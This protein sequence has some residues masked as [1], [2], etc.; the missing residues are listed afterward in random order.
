MIRHKVATV[1]VAVLALWPVAA[2]GQTVLGLDEVLQS[3]RRFAPQVLE[4]VA[5]VRRAEGRQLSAEGAF[6]T[7]VSAEASARITGFWDGRTL[8]GTI[9][10]P[11]TD[12]GGQIYGGYRVSGGRFP[13]YEDRSFTNALGE[14]KV[15]AALSL[16]RDRAIDDRR[17]SRDNA[18]IDVDLAETERLF[19]AITVQR[20]AIAAYNNW[21]VAG[22]RLAIYRDLLALARGR[23]NG[24][25]RQVGAGARPRIIL[26]ENEQNVLR[27]QTLVARAEQD[28]AL[29][30]NTLSLFLRDEEGRPL[31]PAT[32]RLPPALPPLAPRTQDMRAAI[33]RRPDLQVIDLRLAKAR[34]QL[35][36]N[37]NALKPRLDASV[38]FSKDV[39]AIGPGGR[40]RTAGETIVGLRFSVPLQQRA[41]KGN[42]AQTSAEIDATRRRRQQIEEQITAELD[43]LQ[44]D[45]AGTERLRE[46]ADA[47]SDRAQTLAKAEA[48]RFD[49]GASDFFLV[50]AREETAADAH[51]RK[52]DAAARQAAARAELA[53]SAVDLK[54]L[55][56]E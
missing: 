27:R 53:A 55:G 10:R 33:E 52:L 45:V 32:A 6:D 38:E 48:R 25:A 47:E 16:L 2:A 11:L 28:L 43:A 4:A 14:F 54:L 46:L 18:A 42:I 40:S 35:L 20:R 30:G 24:L 41:A 37:N 1:L 36:L 44:I 5:N 22:L 19:T 8:G 34:N 56:L 49:A 7:I 29:A 23:Q 51:I 50:N 21:V 12:W 13:I 9:T 3:S 31:R 39:G 17:F 26:T 15:G